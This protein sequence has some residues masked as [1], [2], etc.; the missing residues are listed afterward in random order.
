MSL[1]PLMNSGSPEDPSKTDNEPAAQKLNRN[2]RAFGILLAVALIIGTA[3]GI[4]AVVLSN[5]LQKVEHTMQSQ[6]AQQDESLHRLRDRLGATE[7]EFADLQVDLT[8]TKDHLGKTQ[9]DL[10]KARQMAD[11]L[12]KEQK[13]NAENLSGQLGALQ[14]AQSST[15]G[16]VG[17]LSS[18]VTGVK[19]EVSTTKQDLASTRTELQRVIGDLGVQSGLVAHNREELAELRLRGERDYYEFDLRKTKQPQKYLGG[20]AL[21]LKKTDT[22]RQKYTLDLI[23]DDRRIEKKD[24]NTNEPVQFYQQG[25]RV[26]TEIVVNQI[27]K[28][29]IVGYI[30]MPKQKQASVSGLEG[31]AQPAGSGS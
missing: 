7:E 5:R 10:R 1:T 3:E 29:R 12:A 25:N 19:Q 16:T 13:E 24:K 2:F 27:Y 22:K 21:Q 30:S 17:S 6:L 9:I 31:S 23:A 28:D 8:S 4:Y 20:V 14:Q 15:S 11:Q 26:P 18:E